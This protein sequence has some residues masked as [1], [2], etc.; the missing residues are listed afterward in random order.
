M[1][2]RKKLLIGNAPD[3]FL[4]G[5]NQ[6]A[7]QLLDKK[8]IGKIKFGTAI[9]AFPGIQSYHPNPEPWF[10]KKEEVQL[11]IWGLTI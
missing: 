11:L 4:G 2:E 8:I 1:H 10:K 7:R 9:F 5:G 6:M 3:T